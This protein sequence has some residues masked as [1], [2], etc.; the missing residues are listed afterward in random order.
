MVLVLIGERPGLSSPDS[1]GAYLTFAPRTGLTDEARN[2]ISNIRPGGLGF[3]EAAFR[4]AWLIDQGFRQSLTGVGLKD[5]S[6]AA[7]EAGAAA[8]LLPQG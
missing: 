2:C 1:L 8:G 3:A 7:L 6:D 4:L 5:E